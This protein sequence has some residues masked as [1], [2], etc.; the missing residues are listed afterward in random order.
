MPVLFPVLLSLAGILCGAVINILADDLPNRARPGVPR[1]HAC[2][3]SFR[4][5]QVVAV[6]A[7]AVG[8]ARCIQCGAAL[9]L[10]RPVVEIA[11][12]LVLVFVYL[13]FG[14]TVKAALLALFL[15]C[16]LLITVIDF[17]H[18]LILYITVLPAAL[19]G[20]AYG[21]FATERE[22]GEA[23]RR[24]LIGGAVGFGVLYAF[25]LLGFAYSAWVTRRR[26]EPLDEVAFGGGDANLGGV[27]GLAVGWPGIILTLFY[28]VL[29][30]GLVA[31]LYL[32]IMFLRRR[33]SLLTPIP[34]GPFIVL[35]AGVVLLFA[36]ELRRIYGQTP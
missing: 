30:G 17:E 28:T 13:R 31:G 15:E 3:F 22:G 9:R 27:V 33:N 32:L 12:A 7:Y 18:R 8:Q 24:T 4:R 23:L 10:R 1:C 36:D 11:A 16:L 35:G 21:V 5:S 19:V 6:W 34:Y 14:L 2:H 25:Y 20:L 26:G 29:S